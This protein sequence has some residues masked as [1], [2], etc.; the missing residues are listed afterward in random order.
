VSGIVRNLKAEEFS[1]DSFD[2]VMSQIMVEI[3]SLFE[4]KQK[5]VLGKY[6]FPREQIENSIEVSTNP[7]VKRHQKEFERLY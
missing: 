1:K 5:V 6:P 3:Q 4:A 7:N 2:T